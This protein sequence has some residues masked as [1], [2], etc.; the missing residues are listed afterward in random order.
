MKSDTNTQNPAPTTF[1]VMSKRET[2]FVT[3]T[4]EIDARKAF[5]RQYP[6]KQIKAIAIRWVPL[7]EPL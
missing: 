6:G 7:P 1:I 3:A 5:H 2:A 4:K